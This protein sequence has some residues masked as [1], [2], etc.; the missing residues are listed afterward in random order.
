M[1][2]NHIFC[3]LSGSIRYASAS[4]GR[5]RFRGRALPRPRS[6]PQPL[7]A[8][9]PRAA[10]ET[11]TGNRRRRARAI[12]PGT[13]RS[14][15]AE[16]A[17]AHAWRAAHGPVLRRRGDSD[18][19]GRRPAW[20]VGRETRPLG[21]RWPS[22]G[23]DSPGILQPHC[24]RAASHG[25]RPPGAPSTCWPRSPPALSGN[26]RPRRQRNDKTGRARNAAPRH[27]IFQALKRQRPQAPPPSGR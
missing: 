4:P 11:E 9:T 27:R 26:R 3:V 22:P 21:G 15:R 25:S 8:P 1:N 23:S 2:S 24:R 10:R 18:R 19:T 13:A 7:P 16:P 17:R 6:Y 5:G 14:R 12:H 20:P